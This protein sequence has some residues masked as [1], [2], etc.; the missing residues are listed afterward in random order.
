[1]TSI[2]IDCSHPVSLSPMLLDDLDFYNFGQHFLKVAVSDMDAW[3]QKYI[4]TQ[5]REISR[6][7][8]IIYALLNTPGASEQC[9]HIFINNILIREAYQKVQHAQGPLV[10]CTGM[11]KLMQLYI[12]GIQNAYN[13]LNQIPE[14]LEISQWIKKC[15]I[16]IHL[17][18]F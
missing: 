9:K 4:T 10:Y 8:S 3:I 6:R 15:W 2:W 16:P 17:N 5:S 14:L 12:E 7:S 1:M 11:L 18:P 13:S